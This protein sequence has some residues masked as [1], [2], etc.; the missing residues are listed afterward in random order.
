MLFT[1][2]GSGPEL[3]DLVAAA[4]AV[5]SPR[6]VPVLR[7]RGADDRLPHLRR[8]WDRGWFRISDVWG[9]LDA[10]PIL[11]SLIGRMA[12]PVM[13]F[14]PSTAAAATSGEIGGGYP[15]IWQSPDG[16]LTCTLL[17]DSFDQLTLVIEISAAHP[18]GDFV[19]VDLGPL[20]DVRRYLLP[21]R[22]DGGRCVADA[23]LDERDAELEVRLSDL[24]GPDRLTE[25]DRDTVLRSVR[26]ATPAGRNTWRRLARGLAE[27]D[28]RAT[29]VEGLTR[30]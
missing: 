9:L 22:E 8:G 12:L 21:L 6:M 2:G 4:W 28:L 15:R 17:K 27:E 11:A 23:V 30:T 7:D 16:L 25:A 19:H 29:I 24:T 13:P 26:A 10:R 20:G 5:E 3:S 1:V 14:Q 18:D